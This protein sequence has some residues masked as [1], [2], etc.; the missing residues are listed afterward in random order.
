MQ[1]SL[2]WII[3]LMVAAIA[4]VSAL[5]VRTEIAGYILLWVFCILGHLAKF[6]SPK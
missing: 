6:P 2:P 4:I 1:L 5:P 3:A